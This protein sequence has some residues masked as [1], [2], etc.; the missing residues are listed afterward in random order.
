MLVSIYKQ[1]CYLASIWLVLD[2]SNLSYLIIGTESLDNLYVSFEQF[3]KYDICL[4]FLPLTVYFNPDSEK[5]S[6]IL[7]N[8]NKSGIYR[9]VNLKSGKSYIG[10]SVNL[11]RR[12]TE[13]Y[14]IGWLT[15]RTNSSSLICRALLK[16]GY[17]GFKLEILEYCASVDVLKR[18]QYYLDL[19]NPEYNLLKVAGSRLGS[20]HTEATKDKMRGVRGTMTISPERRAAL[21]DNIRKFNAKPMEQ[22]RLEKLRDHISKINAKRALAVEVTDTETGNIV[23]YES[24]RQAARELGTTRER[25]STMLKN[26]KLF[27]GKYR[28]STLT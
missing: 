18:E 14:S 6:I 13:Y 8:K 15:Y 28:L 20:K 10:S 11:S 19:F 24:V 16:Y 25:L 26:N 23:K 9:W 21:I 1:N 4:N 22:E 3:C 12:F 27:K 2:V 17:S 5:V 7:D